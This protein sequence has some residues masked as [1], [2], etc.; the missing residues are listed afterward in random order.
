MQKTLNDFKYTLHF[1]VVFGIFIQW[2]MK[3]THYSTETES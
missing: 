1:C 2:K 3:K